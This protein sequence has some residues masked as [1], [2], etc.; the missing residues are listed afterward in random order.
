MEYRIYNKGKLINV[1][2]NVYIVG[3]NISSYWA[4]YGKENIEVK[5]FDNPFM[6]EEKLEWLSKLGGIKC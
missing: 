4:M 2:S 1:C 3:C 6:D 5:V